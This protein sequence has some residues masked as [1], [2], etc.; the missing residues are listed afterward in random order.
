VLRDRAPADLALDRV[1]HVADGQRAA[2]ESS[3]VDQIIE[4]GRIRRDGTDACLKCVKQVRGSGLVSG[5]NVPYV[6]DRRGCPLHQR[7]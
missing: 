3:V 1:Q 6:C 7:T 4:R 2:A 5:E